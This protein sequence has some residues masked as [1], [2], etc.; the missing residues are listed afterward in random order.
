MK[1]LNLIVALI[2]L[3]AA[4]HLAAQTRP[5]FIF[6]I[7]DDQRADALGHVQKNLG[8]AGR[9]PWFTNSTPNIDKLASQGARFRT[10][11]VTSAICSPS[12]A[13]FLTGRYNHLNGVA[14]NTTPF[15]PSNTTW[16][17][18]LGDAGYKTDYI[19]KWHMQK[20]TE[21]PGFQYHA[22]YIGQGVYTNCNFRVNG[23]VTNTVGWVDDVSTD[24]ALKKIQ[25][26]AAASEPFAMV[27]GFKSPH[28]PF[29]PPDRHK[30]KFSTNTPRAVVATN[31]P[32]YTVT[33]PNLRTPPIGD[34]RNYFR[35]LCGVDD[36][37]GRIMKSLDQLGLTQNTVVIY[38]SDNGFFLGEHR[39]GDKRAAY[40]NSIRVPL[41]FRYPARVPAGKLVDQITLNIDLAPT[42]LE[43]AGLP[44]PQDIQGSSWVPLLTNQPVSW[45]TGFFYEY[46][47]E[48]FPEVPTMTA[49]RTKTAKIIKYYNQPGWTEL[50]DLTTDSHE[51]FNRRDNPSYSTLH[52]SMLNLYQQE[53]DAVGYQI[54]A[55]VGYGQTIP[56]P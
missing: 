7:T 40:E 35:S 44:I 25:E 48:G 31:L 47:K 39:L 10:A 2:L 45:R 43:L 33:H 50:F 23:I 36:N 9:F 34:I 15:P 46:F 32:P 3:A 11:F 26:H 28:T 29:T 49:Y 42:I 53:H 41:I 27:I 16:A 18:L 20:Q 37:V 21:R 5:N 6:M 22:S 19:G 4:D 1:I 12:R 17:S 24:F 14:N 13:A 8:T 52:N 38:T 56:T 54:P 51:R 55:Y 30:T